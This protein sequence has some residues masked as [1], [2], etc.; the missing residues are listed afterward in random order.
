M[1]RQENGGMTEIVHYF[2][3]SGY[4]LITPAVNRAL[5]EREFALL[6][7]IVDKVMAIRHDAIFLRENPLEG[8]D[9]DAPANFWAQSFLNHN[10]S[11]LAAKD[12]STFSNLRLYCYN[13]TGRRL[14]ENCAAAGVPLLDELPANLDESIA[15]RYRSSEKLLRHFYTVTGAVPHENTIRP[16]SVMAEVGILVNGIIVN[17]DT[18]H[19]Q[20]S[21]NGLLKSGVID[22]LKMKSDSGAVVRVLE[23][24]AGFGA[25][26]FHLLSKLAHAR[27]FIVDLPESLAFS[28]AYLAIAKPDLK[29]LV[30]GKDE[31]YNGTDFD[32][33]D[34]IFIP[35]H[36][37]KILRGEL[38]TLDCVINV[39]SLSE[40][41]ADQVAGYAD[42]VAEALAPTG[43]FYEQNHVSHE[44]HVDIAPILT[45]RFPFRHVVQNTRSVDGLPA[46]YLDPHAEASV[47]S[48]HQYRI[49][50]N[51]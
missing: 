13:F 15:L 6:C 37:L 36:F 40:M 49:Y 12:R 32:D 18:I 25:L 3:D 7:G 31:L 9:F 43:V 21:M 28:A 4:P 46:L 8:D 48:M 39:M 26:A 22:D 50:G 45:E 14:L 47:W 17:L 44:K 5:T 10:F 1:G 51:P 34:I 11:K 41:S 42:I 27:Y 16:P 30:L 23:I 19:Y 2:C 24:G 35:N 29:Q 33:Y 20:T 38:A